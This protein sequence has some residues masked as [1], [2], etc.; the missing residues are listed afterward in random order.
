MIRDTRPT[1]ENI[2]IDETENTPSLEYAMLF[3]TLKQI[4]D[5]EIKLAMET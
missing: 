3:K 2:T 4:L 1:L 5:N